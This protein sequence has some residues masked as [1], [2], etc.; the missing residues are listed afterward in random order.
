[1]KDY[2]NILNISIDNFNKD[3][4]KEAYKNKISQ[5][6]D[7]PFFTKT[8]IADIKSIKEALYIFNDDKLK[9]LYDVKYKKMID[10]NKDNTNKTI[11]NK[12]DNTKICD[13]LFS[14]KF[15]YKS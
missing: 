11:D 1:M 10:T 2:Y 9:E 13:R 4:L 7:L 5:F 6:N 15:N 3:L 8:M 12:I 14:I